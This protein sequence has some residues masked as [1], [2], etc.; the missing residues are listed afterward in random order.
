MLTELYRKLIARLTESGFT[1]YAED[2]VPQDAAF[3]FVMCRIDAPSS[4][5]EVGSIVLTGWTRSSAP[6]ADRLLMADALVSLVPPGGL[7]LPLPGGLAAVFRTEARAVTWPEN[8][9]ALGTCIRHGLR[10]IW[11]AV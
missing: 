4:M 1:A 11:K 10:V 6:H 8:K 9:G 3:P 5:H 2:A 7:L